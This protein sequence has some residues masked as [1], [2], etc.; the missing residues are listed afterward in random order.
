MKWK[1]LYSPKTKIYLYF[2]SKTVIDRSG[3][4]PFHR[5]DFLSMDFDLWK[6]IQ[7]ILRII[8]LK[9]RFKWIE[10]HQDD[11][12]KKGPRT[13]AATLNIQVDARAGALSAKMK[14]HVPTLTIPSSQ[15]SIS[16]GNVQYHHFPATAIR[17]HVHKPGLETYIKEKTGWTDAA[18][19]CIDWEG[20][21]GALKEC[22]PA[23]Q[24]NWIKL[25]HNWQHTGRQKQAYGHSENSW[26]CPF[27]CGVP[28]DPLHY[29]V[30]SSDLATT[31]KQSHIKDLKATLKDIGTHPPLKRAV[32]EAIESYCNIP[33]SD[34]FIP[35]FQSKLALTI[36]DAIQQQSQLGIDNLLKGRVHQLITNIQKDVFLKVSNSRKKNSVERFIHHR[37]CNLLLS[38][39]D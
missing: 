32:V 31:H 18:F 26:S 24:V 1:H 22:A 37:P 33:R 11:K 19:K 20:Y 36:L 7:R 3:R 15:I 8:P 35:A 6:E 5:K 16:I 27:Q 9:I 13:D 30:C 12:K 38:N 4:R 2:D 28:D 23:Q 29:C 14:H 25:A 21:E 10:S 39:L 17:N 34:T